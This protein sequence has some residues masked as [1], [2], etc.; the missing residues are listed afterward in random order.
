M[1][2]DFIASQLDR[3]TDFWR[4]RESAA[5]HEFSDAVCGYP[6]RVTA[7]HPEL[8]AAARLSARRFSRCAPVAGGQPIALHY[9]LDSALPETPVPHDWPQR[10][11][12][13]GAGDWLAVNAEP[14]V[15]AFADLRRWVGVAFVSAPL[16]RA[17][18]MLSRFIGDTFT[19]NMLLRTGWGQLHASCLWR[20]GRAVLLTAP[21]NSGKSTTAFRLVMNGYRLLSDGMTY[22]RVHGRSP[23]RREC[24]TVRL[25]G[26]RSQT[27]LRHAG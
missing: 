25:P 1:S 5:A 27:A 13:M 9:I 7:N 3:L 20:D 26:R 19:L 14:W 12:H 8:L 10:L 6:Y 21:H 16:M 4:R 11:R 2:Q 18:Y 24:G 15:N 22:V 17:P 23:G